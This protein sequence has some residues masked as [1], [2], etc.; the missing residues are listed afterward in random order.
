MIKHMGLEH[1]NT[2]MGRPT[3]ENGCRTDNMGLELKSG[4]MDQNMRV[5]ILMDRKTEMDVLLLRTKVSLQDNFSKIKYQESVNI[6]GMI[7]KP[8][9]VIGSTIKCTDVGSLLGQMEKVMR[10]NS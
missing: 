9:L 2:L 3:L 5:N 1:I 6:L 8:M 10:V 4:L 7:K